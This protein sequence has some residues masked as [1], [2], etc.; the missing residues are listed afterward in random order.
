MTFV[1]PPNAD[2]TYLPPV[3]AIP[4]ALEITAISN[5]NPMVVTVDANSDQ[6]NTYMPGQKVI[7]TIPKTYGM[8]QANGLTGMITAIGTNTLTLNIY[9]ANFD[10]FV[11]PANTNMVATLA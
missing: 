4:S 2:N 9:S 5:T 7:L 11:I 10:P 8:W 6:M 1:L 3:V